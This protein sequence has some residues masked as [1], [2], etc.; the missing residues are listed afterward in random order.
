[1]TIHFNEISAKKKKAFHNIAWA[2]CGKIFSLL[3]VLVVG[4]IVARYIGK[5]QY[6]IMNYV[7]SYIAIFQVFA[8]FGLDLIQIREESKDP[9]ARDKIIGTVWGLRL[10]FA[11]CTLIVI[12]FT[13]FLFVED[14]DIRTYIMIYAFSIILN[15][16]WVSRNHFTSIVW[17]E[18][19]VKTEISRSIIG[20]LIKVLLVVF[21]FPLAWFIYSLLIDSLLLATGYTISYTKKIDSIRK[22]HFDKHLAC[23]MLQQSFP[24]LLSGTAIII[25]NRI[26]QIMI[27]NMID[28]SN[29]GI[30]SVAVRFVELLVFVPT[31]IS[32]TISPMLVEIYTK[33]INQYEIVSRRFINISVTICI[34][35]AIVTSLLSYPLI[36]FTF[37]KVYIDAV[38]ILAILSF[39][40]V[41]DALSQTSGQLIIIEGVQKYAPIRNII[42]CITC[43]TLNLIFITKYGILGVAIVAIITIFISG[44]FANF[45]IPSYRSIFIKQILA[46]LFGW[47]DVVHIK[48][49]LK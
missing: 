34:I 38:P 2:L 17:N 43:V 27:G 3:S 44:T 8:D 7:I 41:G 47:K 12:A 32:Q 14:S 46:I 23:Y 21:H 29:L 10:F 45:I 42:G 24:L 33:D 49:L 5:E 39:K 9:D 22:W 25:Y 40:V 37:G 26:D 28:Q 36:Y 1:M 18:Y 20:I 31:I 19:V 15:T 16:T 11:I 4:I 6:G 35:L 30:Y 48:T 13:T